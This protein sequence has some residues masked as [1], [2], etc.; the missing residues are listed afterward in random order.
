MKVTFRETPWFTEA[1]T[2]LLQDDEYREFR[3]FLA[4]NPG[5]GEVIPG[6]E[7]LR[8]VRWSAKG[9]GKRGGI[10]TIYY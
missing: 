2:A 6:G 10:R 7:G 1:I 5:F 3:A 4:E 9:Y 8:K